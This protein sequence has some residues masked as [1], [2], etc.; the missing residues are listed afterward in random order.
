MRRLV[1]FD[2]KSRGKLLVELFPSTIPETE[3]P[4][5]NELEYIARALDAQQSSLILIPS[6]SPNLVRLV[7]VRYVPKP[8]A[9]E[10]EPGPL[11]EAT[12]FLGLTD[13]LCDP[14]PVKEKPWW[15]RLWSRAARH[16]AEA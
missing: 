3:A 15:R 6:S 11:Y 4:A 12:G 16:S 13:S 2:E 8:V 1:V 14:E 5:S 10:A 7:R 9:P